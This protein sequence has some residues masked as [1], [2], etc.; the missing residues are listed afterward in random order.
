[1]NAPKRGSAGSAEESD[2][3]TIELVLAPQEFRAL[4]RAA[5]E[6]GRLH[7]AV[8]VTPSDAPASPDELGSPSAP[9]V[10]PEPS[11]AREP[12]DSTAACASLASPSEDAE[13]EPVKLRNRI[14]KLTAA[15][16]VGVAAVVIAVASAVHQSSPRPRWAP[17]PPLPPVAAVTA[18]AAPTP[19][20]VAEPPVQYRNPF[21][22]SEVFEFP[23]GTSRDDA[24][25]AV[26]E[27]LLQRAQERHPA[28]KA[29]KR[30]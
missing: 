29:T 18:P 27:I 26:A 3:D 19:E 4:L 2:E 8:Y 10:V 11:V 20:P 25:K 13:T 23:A 21:D 22:R 5:E 6:H 17:P 16:A 24:R 30:R 15:G 7:A 9:S 28:P 12:A 14:I 1:M